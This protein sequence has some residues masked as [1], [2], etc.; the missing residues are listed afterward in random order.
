MQ[1]LKIVF[2][3]GLTYLPVL[4]IMGVMLAG[5]STKK[6]ATQQ[7]VSLWWHGMAHKNR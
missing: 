5:C 2:L 3:L 7:A 4:V 6:T 1:K